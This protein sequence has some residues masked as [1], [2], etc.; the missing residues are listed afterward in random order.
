M[1]WRLARIAGALEPFRA[2]SEP[3]PKQ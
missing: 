3:T 2:L 1:K